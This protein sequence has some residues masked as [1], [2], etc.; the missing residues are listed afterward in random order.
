LRIDRFVVAGHSSGGAYAVVCA[1]RLRDRVHGAV[2]VAGVTDMQWPAGWTEYLDGRVE[3][4][5]MRMANEREAVARATE[6]FGA[7]GAGF[8]T[9]RFD[10]PAPDVALLAEPG[11]ED[12]LGAALIEAF[13]QGVAAYAQDAYLEGRGWSFDAAQIAS[14]TVLVHGQQDNLVP[15]AHSRHTAA[16]I[17]GSTLRLL[18]DHGHLTILSELPAI[19]ASLSPSAA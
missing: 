13:R 1:A 17:P 19:A 6:A 10:L 9:Q 7:D 11:V 18:P 14:P 15:V 12:A 16:L 3:L 2:V 8:M 4:Q 5:I